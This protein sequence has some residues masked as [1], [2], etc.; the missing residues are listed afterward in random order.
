MKELV[1]NCMLY[2]NVEDDLS[3]EDAVDRLLMNIDPD[4]PIYIN[5]SHFQDENGEECK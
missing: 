5:T 2:L 1:V 3:L 4:V